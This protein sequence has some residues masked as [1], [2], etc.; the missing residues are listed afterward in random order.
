MIDAKSRIFKGTTRFEPQRQL[1]SGGFGEVY[2]VYDKERDVV[3]ALKTLR[4]TDP[5]ALYRFKQEFRAIADIVHP[6]LV[7][8]YELLSDG[9]QWFF[10][11]ELVRGVNF[12][13][14][15]NSCNKENKH[16]RLNHLRKAVIQLAEGIHTLHNANKLHCDLKPSNVLVTE[17]GRV[18]ILDFGLVTELKKRIAETFLH[19]GTPEYVAPE[20]VIG[21]PATKA[22]DWY[23]LGVML[24]EVLSGNLPFDNTFGDVLTEKQLYEPLPPSSLVPDLPADLDALCQDLLKIDPDK[25]PTGDLVLKRLGAFHT[26]A[27][28]PVVAANNSQ[29]SFLIGRESH[30]ASLKD[31]FQALKQEN[32]AINYVQGLSGMGKSV[33]IRHFLDELLIDEPNTVV[34]TGRCYEQESVPYKA[35]DNVIDNLAQYLKT[36]PPEEIISLI[37]SNASA[38]ARLFPVLRQVEGFSVG[39]IKVAIPDS[40]ELRRRAFL[41]LRQLFTEL[42]NQH[43]VIIYIDDLQWG[44]LDSVSLLNE[45]LR[46]P[47]PPKLFLIFSYRSD[48]IETSPFLK[49]LFSSPTISSVTNTQKI[50]VNELLEV[51][52]R[53]LV[54]ELLDKQKVSEERVDL[55]VRESAGNPFFIHELVRYAQENTRLRKLI[56]N[57]REMRSS[58]LLSKHSLSDDSSSSASLDPESL[59]DAS[60]PIM[61]LEDVI[62]SRITQLPLAA[63]RL[64]EIIAVVGQPI[65][66]RIV[67]RA[68][69]LTVEEPAAVA[70][71]RTNN[72]IRI[73]GLQVSD[74]IEVYHDRIRETIIKKLSKDKLKEYHTNIVTILEST[75]GIDP[76]DLIVHFQGAGNYQKA[77]EYACLAADKAAETLAF[78]HASKLY[79][80]AIDFQPQEARLANLEEKLGVAL[81][82]AGR[83]IEA[84]QAYLL[85]A[86]E[87]NERFKVLKLKQVAAEQ[88]LR[89]GHIDEGLSVLRDI[90]SELGMTLPKNPWHS[91]LLF[92]IGRFRLWLRGLDFKERDIKDIPYE[93]I[94][95]I[96]ICWS[97]ATGLVMIDTIRGSEFQVRYL[98]YALELGDIYRLSRAFCWE[99]AF[100]A[101]S[102]TFQKGNRVEKF[103]KL[104]KS[105][106]DKVDNPHAEGLFL[107]M[108]GISSFLL[109]QWSESYELNKKAGKILRTQCTGVSWEAYTAELFLLRSLF[110]MGRF[111]EI[112][113]RAFVGVKEA[114]ER[115]NLYAETSLRTRVSYINYLILDEPDS[116]MNEIDEAMEK[117]SQSGF[118]AQ[119]YYSCLARGEIFLY[120]NKVEEVWSLTK[121]YWPK[122]KRSM[123]L[124]VQILLI[125]SLH[126]KARAAICV[127]IKDNM[128]APVLKTIERIANRLLKENTA[129]SLG[130]AHSAF[131]A[132]AC[133][134]K[135]Y[136]EAIKHLSTA[137]SQFAIVNMDLYK[138]VAQRARGKL[139]QGTQGNSLVQEAEELIKA[140]QVQNIEAFSQ[141]LLPGNWERK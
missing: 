16:T 49:A 77:G 58:L 14:Y 34:L 66:R 35:F 81:A 33:L 59:E 61:H 7:T 96:D 90:L 100:S 102:T 44:D 30:L 124:K 46:S 56:P 138:A 18:I 31:S 41:A 20:I 39:R 106:V 109:G 17:K 72:L 73:R 22:S 52:A 1:G 114:Q 9:E 113:E 97:A 122:L 11:M 3:V 45:L 53:R 98:L 80:I 125:E 36:L 120:S 2:Q 5:E 83:T 42:G 79:R 6:N 135:N 104:A 111:Q 71:L 48:E 4:N 65:E 94:V 10:T 27:L 139:T 119:H 136:D 51:D 134:N 101:T 123:M 99:I 128:P 88:L 127:A 112:F 60:I 129:C 133:F 32:I 108:S 131:A 21:A 23:S 50:T 29:S 57:A 64:M 68:A 89:G 54:L 8:L 141:M 103:S 75:E 13:Q 105:L 84:A 118:H 69:S 130:F 74:K 82:N 25:R 15:I 67:K 55:I 70:L 28:T 121:E 47:N 19:Y 24:Y 40:Q 132:L 116:A 12:L 126:L 38:L 76:E 37:P 107:L 110:F 62:Y 78:D 85:A 95:K 43:P 140:Q 87:N 117:W 115:G 26:S 91:A 92:L 137:E 86:G 63:Q 93:Q